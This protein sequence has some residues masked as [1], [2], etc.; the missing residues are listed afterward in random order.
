WAA[1][2]RYADPPGDRLAK[3]H[4]A[5]ITAID[6]RSVPQAVVDSYRSEGLE[7]TLAAKGRNVRA[8]VWEPASWQHP[9]AFPGRAGTVGGILAGMESSSIFWAP[10]LFL[11]VLPAV[12]GRRRRSRLR[13]V[14]PLLVIVGAITL[15]WVLLEFGGS[16]PSL[17]WLHQSPYA[18]FLLWCA[19]PVLMALE[20]APGVAMALLFLQVI[21]SLGVW[22]L[23]VPLE[24]AI[25][26]PHHAGAT[27]PAMLG[28]A[29]IGGAL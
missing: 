6:G 19:V 26:S 1:Y 17:A 13:A 11:L 18:L 4:L 28:L 12:F 20:L 3:W 10:G 15:A 5:G 24:A 8:L 29:L 23:G 9:R 2:Q 25:P 14:R 21:V 7:G 22:V 27:D 16:D